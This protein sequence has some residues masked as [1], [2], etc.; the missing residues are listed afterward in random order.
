MF[1][2]RGMRTCRAEYRRRCIASRQCCVRWW[3]RH[4][5]RESILIVVVVDLRGEHAQSIHNITEDGPLRDEPAQTAS[6]HALQIVIHATC[7]LAL[8]FAVDMAMMRC[9]CGCSCSSLLRT[10]SRLSQ[11]PLQLFLWNGRQRC[12]H[13]A[14]LAQNRLKQARQQTLR[15][16]AMPIIAQRHTATKQPLRVKQCGR[17]VAESEHRRFGHA[18]AANG[19]EQLEQALAQQIHTPAHHMRNIAA[20][21]IELIVVQ[22]D[23]KLI[24]CVAAQMTTH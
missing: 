3:Q 2:S 21:R 12:I 6:L 23:S 7:L 22:R 4:V 8:F 14:I 19:R 1:E 16:G 5:E 15:Y 9:C 20:K 24:P 10:C 11:P 13:C 18:L 17:S